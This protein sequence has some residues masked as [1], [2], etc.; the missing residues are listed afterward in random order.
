MVLEIYEPKTSRLEFTI[1]RENISYTPHLNGIAEQFK[2]IIVEN[3]K[4]I[5]FEYNVSK[6]G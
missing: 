4:T 5:L 6:M 1:N 3:V 2:R